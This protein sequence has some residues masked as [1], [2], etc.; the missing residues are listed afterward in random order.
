[1]QRSE[2]DLLTDAAHEVYAL[3]RKNH[4]RNDLDSALKN[5]QAVL[6]QCPVGHPHRAAALSNLAHAILYG[7]TKGEQTDIDDAISLFRSALAL[8]PQG[9]PDHL[10]SIFDLCKALRQRYSRLRDH[11]DL[12]EAVK[13]LLDLLPTCLEDSYLQLCVIEEC[14]TLPRDPSDESISLRRIVLELCPQGHRHHARSLNRLAGDLYTRF[15]Q[16]GNID[17]INEA[18]HLLR[19]A[20]AACDGDGERSFYLSVL[21]YTLKL[22]FHRLHHTADINECISLSR[23]ALSLHPPGHP[24]RPRSLNNLAKALKA[25]Y[26]QYENA[27]DLKESNDLDKAAHDECS[28]NPGILWSQ[29]SD[30]YIDVGQL[31]RTPGPEDG[32]RPH[33][34]V[35]S[36]LNDHQVRASLPDLYLPK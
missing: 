26:D 36:L 7:F 21:S 23:E 2:L 24:A 12:R 27:A 11:T 22:R 5:F 20:L 6:E 16:S 9:H 28:E 17:D 31:G 30:E 10:L 15:E 33:P 13:R 3:Y 8:C 1:M 4:H 18:T 32:Q 35:K 34:S 14:H 25:R 19:E 29:D